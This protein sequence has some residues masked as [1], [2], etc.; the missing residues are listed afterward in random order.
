MIAI[1]GNFAFSFILGVLAAV[2]PCGFV[3]LPT[4]LMFFLGL[5]GSRPDTNQRATLRRSLFVGTATSSGFVA[6]FLIVGL[7][8]RLFTSQIERNAKYASLVIGVALVAMGI[9]MLLGWK[10]RIATP[11]MTGGKDRT[12][13]SMFLFGIAYAIA[14]IGCTIGFL[15]TVVFGS[16]NRHGFV[17]GVLSTVLYGLGM[18]AIVTALTVTLAFA[19]GGLLVLLRSGMQYLDRVSAVFVVFTGVYLTWYWYA[20]ITESRPGSL[21][22]RVESWQSDIATFLQRQ[23]AWKLAAVFGGIILVAMI[24]VRFGSRCEATNDV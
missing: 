19:K 11:A 6:V 14:S 3:L 2:N 18:G 16:V 22:S 21:V 12:V 13:R 7:I 5:E 23:G 20:A 1:E 4:Y 15:T 8:S 17:S 10:P 9:G 24:V